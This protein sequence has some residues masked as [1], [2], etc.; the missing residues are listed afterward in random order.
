MEGHFTFLPPQVIG[1]HFASEDVTTHNM[2]MGFLELKDWK[3]NKLQTLF[4]N[5][6]LKENL[7]SSKVV[8]SFW[9]KLIPS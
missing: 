7:A 5:K 8:T 3:P 2:H 4:L 6:R 1:Q 9:V